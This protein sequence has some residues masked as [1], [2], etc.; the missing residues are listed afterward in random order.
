MAGA[1]LP[2]PAFTLDREQFK[3]ELHVKALRIPT[4]KCQQYLALLNKCVRWGGWP[5]GWARLQL[6]C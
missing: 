6:A 4:K 5:L 3:E 2:G 1:A